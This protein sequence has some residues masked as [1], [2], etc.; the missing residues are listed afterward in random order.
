MYPRGYPHDAAKFGG[1]ASLHDPRH[2]LQRKSTV[3]LNMGSRRGPDRLYRGCGRTVFLLV[4]RGYLFT[5]PDII[6]SCRNYHGT[7]SHGSTHF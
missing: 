1:A 4:L 7:L 3:T 2:H 5:Y 6:S